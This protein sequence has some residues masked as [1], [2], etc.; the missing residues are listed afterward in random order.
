M[1]AKKALGEDEVIL[2]TLRTHA[3]VLVGAALVLLV[4]AL[5]GGFAA[6]MM[7]ASWQPVGYILLAAVLAMVLTVWVLAPFLRW[8]T[9]TY[10]ITSRRVITRKG[11]LNRS[12]HTVPLARIT[13]VSYERSLLDRLL[14]CGTLRLRTAAD[15]QALT[16]PD[17]PDVEKVQLMLT[18][19]LFHKDLN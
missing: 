12:G 7:P 11:I 6:A 18:E 2:T 17:V 8:R 10:T 9:S 14:G 4:A 19:L 16:L 5:G 13:D 3:K 1:S 15:G